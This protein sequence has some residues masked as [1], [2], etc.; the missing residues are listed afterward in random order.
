M[1]STAEEAGAAAGPSPRSP[2]KSPSKSPPLNPAASPDIEV[3][4]GHE[5]ADDDGD[6]LLGGSVASS[7]T[8][9]SASILEFRKIHGRTFHNF[10]TDTEYWGPNDERQNEHLDIN[11]QM[12]LVAMDNK[13]YH[14]PIGDD[15]QRVID[16]GTGTGIWAI[17][18]ADQFPSAEVTGTDISP[19]QPLWVPPN[20]KF[21]LDDAQLTWTYPDNHFDYIHMRLMM[22]SIKD[23]PA[24]YKEVYRCLKPGGWFEHQDYDPR[25][26]SDDGTV[27]SDSPWNQWGKIFIEAGEKLGRTFSVIIDRN[28]YGWMKD[29][30]FENVQEKRIKLPLGSWPADPKWKT[31]GQYN[32]IATEQGLEGFALYVLTN[33]HGWGLEETQ[34]Y[35][36]SVRKELHNRKNHAYYETAS[37]FGQ[38]PKETGEQ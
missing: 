27:G 35:L 12:L 6:S 28:N 19:T 11:H 16:I 21:E 33:V 20:C 23:W 37:V 32:L 25:V 24:L 13:L 3:D 31:I 1:A 9:L 34:V 30:G 26:V 17:D 36:A 8:S 18:F 4:P 7:T 15:P 5:G 22:G 14:A 2:T 29:A 10:N 38:K